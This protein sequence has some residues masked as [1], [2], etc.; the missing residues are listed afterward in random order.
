MYSICVLLKLIFAAK[1]CFVLQI[2]AVNGTVVRSYYTV[3][4]DA[5]EV[6]QRT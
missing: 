2:S 5:A 6:S 1:I 3:K 4:R